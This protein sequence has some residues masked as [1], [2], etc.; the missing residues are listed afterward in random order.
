MKVL[1]TGLS[2]YLGHYLYYYRP[3]NV[4]IIGTYCRNSDDF[5][6][7]KMIRLDLESVDVFTKLSGRY[8]LV[9]H[10]A[11]N[12]SLGD[13]ERNEHRAYRV[14]SEA[15][16]KLARWSQYQ[17]SRF[18][19]LS[20]DI[21]FKGD[22]GNYTENDQPN[23][24]NIYGLSKLEGERAVSAYHTNYTICRLS[25]VLG[26]AKGS[27]KNF[28]DHFIQNLHEGNE[29]PL[30]VDEWRTPITPR[31][32]AHAIWEIALSKYTGIIHLCGAERINRYQL[33][34]KITAYLNYPTDRLQK[35]CSSQ[36]TAYPRPLDVSLRSLF[37]NKILTL[38]Q[39]NISD[40]I[41]EL[42]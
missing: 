12:A 4:Q 42:I 35:A 7:Q 13:C 29:I 11:A 33:G 40:T 5:E 26:K 16:E 31:Y 36:T 3:K 17:G 27:R 30:F 24:V 32:A 21:V 6:A 41:G 15:T 23:P 10:T 8:D 39:Q 38:R 2:G 19:Y 20:T 22:Q 34:M 25:L 28:I 18:I 14:N 37:V 9:I 1:I